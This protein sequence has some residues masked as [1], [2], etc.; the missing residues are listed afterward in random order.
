LLAYLAMHC[1]REHARDAIIERFWPDCDPKR[2]RSNLCSALWRLRRAIGPH[3]QALIEPSTHGETWISE[4]A[5]IWLDVK[6]F[7]RGVMAALGTCSLD[8]D[9]GTLASLEEGLGFYRGE[10]MP[11]WYDDWV[12]AERERLHGLYVSGLMQLMNWQAARNLP[13]AAIATGRQI[14]KV[15]PLHETVHRRL[16]ELYLATGQPAAADRQY[17]DCLRLLMDEPGAAPCPETQ[18]TYA[19]LRPAYACRS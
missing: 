18:S 9:D 16:I 4:S 15:E 19:R 3:G 8:R 14:L 11:G 6:A 13:D 5:P 2:G 17:Q 1:D 12:L 10:L 7:E